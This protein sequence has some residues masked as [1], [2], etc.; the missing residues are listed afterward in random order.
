MSRGALSGRMVGA[1]LAVAPTVIPA[2][3]PS[4]EL[5]DLAAQLSEI[6]RSLFFKQLI[7]NEINR[8]MTIAG[9]M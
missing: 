5:S 9:F 1:A 6:E 8:G 7:F 2:H 3:A 4:N